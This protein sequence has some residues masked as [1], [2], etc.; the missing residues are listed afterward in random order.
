VLLA[1]GAVAVVAS[2]AWA[3]E[4]RHAGSA[5]SN[6][7]AHAT[8]LRKVVRDGKSVFIARLTNFDVLG[9]GGRPSQVV[10]APLY[11]R[12]PAALLVAGIGL[13]ARHRLAAP[14]T[15]TASYCTGGRVRLFSFTGHSG[16]PNLPRPAKASVV[17]HTGYARAT[18]LWPPPVTSMPPDKPQ[19]MLTLYFY[20]PGLAVVRFTQAGRVLDRLTFKV[21]VAS[22]PRLACR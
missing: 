19:W 14:V 7:C 5:A 9:I 22:G 6:G 16:G 13:E 18:L 11:P 17:R 2:A 20:K 1:A 10:T 8:P 12:Y 21:C 3:R 4:A 15:V